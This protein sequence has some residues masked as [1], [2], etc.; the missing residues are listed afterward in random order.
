MSTTYEETKKCCISCERTEK[1]AELFVCKECKQ[2]GKDKIFCSECRALHTHH[3]EFESYIGGSAIE[4]T[5]PQQHDSGND[6]NTNRTNYSYSS[7]IKSVAF[8]CANTVKAQL[9]NHPA[10]SVQATLGFFAGRMVYNMHNYSTYLGDD[11]TIGSVIGAVAFVACC[12]LYDY[13]KAV[14]LQYIVRKNF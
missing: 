10:I 6:N 8:Q 5:I 13:K 1:H 9:S 7:K 11:T 12:T 14:E 2:K 4:S 3:H